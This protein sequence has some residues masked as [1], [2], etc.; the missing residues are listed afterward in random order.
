MMQHNKPKPHYPLPWPDNNFNDKQNV[1]MTL[2][3][4]HCLDNGSL[5]YDLRGSIMIFKK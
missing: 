4:A 2:Y 3:T 1:L 5:Q